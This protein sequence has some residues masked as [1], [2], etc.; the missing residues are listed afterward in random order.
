MTALVHAP[1]IVRVYLRN[2]TP[3]R[4]TQ[5]GA[6]AELE[7]ETGIGPH[8]RVSVCGVQLE[9]VTCG[10]CRAKYTRSER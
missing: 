8:R 1:S 7:D 6:V 5:C 3:A 9:H 10:S 2:G 4:L